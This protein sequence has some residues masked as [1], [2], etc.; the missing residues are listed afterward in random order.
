MKSL[1]SLVLMQLKDKI[2]FTITKDK[3]QLLR[4]IILELVKFIVI[5]AL[6]FLILYLCVQFI[7]THDETPQVL[8]LVLMLTLVLSTISCT[9]QLMKNLYFADD[10]RVLITL[11]VPANKIFISK[12]IVYYLY[13]LKKSFSFLIPIT[14]AGVVLLITKGLCSVLSAIWMIIPMLFIVMLPVLI[15][16]LLSIPAMF[17]YRFLKKYSIIEVILFLVLLILAASTVVYLINLI[18]ENIDLHNQWPIIKEAIRGFLK[19][20][21]E[22]LFVISHLLYS[23]IG[24]QENLKYSFKLITFIEFGVTV[25]VNVI[26]FILVYFLSRPLFFNMMSKNFEIKKNKID[27][28]ENKKRGKY[29]TFIHKEFTINLRTMDI[30][31]NYLMVYIIVPILILFLNAMYKAMDTR[32]LGDLLIYA[33]NILLICL[34]FLASNA[35]VATYYSREGRT[36]Y[37]KKTKPIYALYPLFTKMFFNALFSVPAIFIT[38]IVFGVSVKFTVIQIIIMGFAI[39]FLHLGHM[40]FSAML[41][42]MNPQNE[43]YATTGETFDNPNENKSTIFAFIISFIYALISYKLLSESSIGG[44]ISDL[45]FGMI[46]LMII[47]FGYLMATLMLFIKRIRAFYYEKQG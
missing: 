30:S 16:G 8:I 29:L 23:I 28:R 19:A 47:S 33:F 42:I 21:E 14:L 32:R 18:P 22:K 43:Q 9:A 40:I 6:V 24:A 2:D 13:E 25:F 5:T 37:L 4:L 11:P 10:N 7:F 39:L 3:K 44:N 20:V 31:V 27:S 38:V 17:I 12:I 35:L 1:K 45:S 15:G 46:K 36:G 26:L 41:D 34:P